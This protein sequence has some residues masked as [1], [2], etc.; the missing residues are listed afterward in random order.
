MP[1]EQKTI[2][3]LRAILSADVKGY[4]L[5]MTDD[6]AFTIR[7][8]KVYRKLMSDMIERSTGRVVDAPGDNLLAEFASAV[9]AVQCAVE[10]QKEL[11]LKNDELPDD[12]KLEF[13]IGVN[14]GDVVQD[15]DSLFGE[16]VNIAARVEGLADAGG[17]CI[18]RN[19]YDH[20]R[21]KL[22]FGY[23]YL[24]EHDVKNIKQPVRVY[25]VLMDP[26]D[27]GKLIGVKTKPST[28][29]WAWPMA[30][31]IVVLLG[32]VALQVYEKLTA[33]EFE[34]ASVEEMAYSL[35]EKPSIA[36]LPFVNMSGNPEQE[37]IGDSIA[38]NV[39]TALSYVPE[40]F[41]IARTSTFAYKGKTVKIKQISEDL[42]VRYVLEGSIQKADKRIRVTAQLIDAISGHHLWADR[43]DR[44]IEDFF[45]V[46]DEI[47][48]EVV[49]E[50][51][52]KLTEGDISHIS[53]K[54][55]NFEAWLSAITAYNFVHRTTKEN[56]TKARAL[57]E[58]AVRLDPEYGFAWGGLGAAHN[59]EGIFGWSESQE[60]SFNLAVEYTDKA[61]KLDENLSC[62]TAV[63][64]RLYS[65]QGQHK[66]AIATG[67]K[68]IAIGPSHDLSY[69]TLSEIMLF[70][71]RYEES[72]VLM[73]KAMRLNPYYPAWCLNTL[74][75][76]YFFLEKYEQAIEAGKRL[77][78]RAQ[79]GEYDP[80][81][82]HLDLSVNYMLV[83]R[84]K[85][86]KA[87]AEE[88]MKI[89]PSYSL[90]YSARFNSLYKN[91]ADRE[92]Y[93][94][95][96]RT[97]GYPDKPPLPLPD[98]PSIA[99]L[100]FDNLSGDPE[101]EY[102]SDGISENIITA[103]SKVG[104][105]FVIARNSSFIYKGKPVKV[106]HVG[107]ELGVRYVLEG[108]VQKSGDR[109]R[110]TAQLIDAE[111]G[112][113]LWA[114]NYDRELKS[115]FEIQDEITLKIITAL[116]VNLSY[117][118][119]ARLWSKQEQD[120]DVYLKTSEA[121]SLY[122]DGSRESTIRVGQL[123]QEIVEMAP[124]LSVGY[125]LLGWYYNRLANFGKSP[126]ESMQKAFEMA[127][128]AF[129]LD[130]SDGFN[131][132]LLGY[133]YG[134][135]KQYDKAIQSGMRAVELAPNA[136]LVH[137]IFGNI[138]KDACRFD[139][140][141]VHLKQ[142]IRLDPFPAYYS[143]S[144]LGSC[145]LHTGQYE[146]ALSEYR[147]V[148]KLAP[149]NRS[150]H[151]SLAIVYALLNREKDARE[152]AA[153]AMELIP[154]ISVTGTEKRWWY[155]CNDNLQLVLNAMRKAGFPE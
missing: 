72:I 10:I 2:R 106:Q 59:A 132:A 153:K 124:E 118:E 99:V 105:L 146:S 30:A 4:S 76:N 46:L 68:A 67:K 25:K 47:A 77:L 9:D 137:I 125:R 147:K 56:I 119:Q 140:A 7:T 101:Q 128:K 61:L 21:N 112:Q 39:I 63:K 97:V 51:K 110:I 70:A 23:K 150:I 89:N 54:T 131:H 129:S 81:F 38:E 113:H 145:Y 80:L 130:E 44:N 14:I 15:G 135:M 94:A 66:Q 27:A 154:S 108:S 139:E 20:I 122:N 36:V 28:K 18:S 64:A 60:K 143:Y 65:L 91:Q 107:R 17:I 111:N 155:A 19:A 49:I 3:K 126:R 57:F 74:I 133:I 6:E 152:S 41:V 69:S 114:E 43:Y 55:D 16:G 45:K 116:H 88:V 48:K 90:E 83:G 79:K 22:N 58:K 120:L 95:S 1:E 96:L 35:P 13:R 104:D 149:N 5:L 109:I 138:L 31:A 26:E 123:A 98:K 141:L 29:K 121:A 93:I 8:L 136:A 84:D 85:Y 86:A 73:E 11:K 102:F 50:L 75:M 78:E 117:G 40:M 62:A 53:H 52:V 87:H 92:R 127:Q 42:G 115:I 148:L 134:A 34:P 33:P 71:G 24:G 151:I 37:Y 82:A 103:L 32:F 12:K 100:A 144:S 142:A